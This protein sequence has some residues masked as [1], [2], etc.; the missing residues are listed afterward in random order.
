MNPSS[1]ICGFGQIAMFAALASCSAAVGSDK[2][3][4]GGSSSSS[5]A[6][7]AG[8]GGSGVDMGGGP[9]GNSGDDP[10]HCVPGIP[11][12]TQLRRMQNWQYDATVRDL[13]GVTARDDRRRRQ[14]AVGAA[15][16]RL[17]R[18]DGPRR[19][20]HLPGRRRGDRQGGH[21]QRDA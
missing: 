21:G 19:V 10:I 3:G 18:P 15:V 9:G 12:T 4:S 1:R 17:R 11:A 20:A 5:G 16:R 7:T 13:L 6:G 14:A 8:S 2:G